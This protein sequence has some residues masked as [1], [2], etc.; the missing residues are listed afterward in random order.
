MPA[1]SRP[2]QR[3]RRLHREGRQGPRE[4]LAPAGPGRRVVPG[5]RTLRLNGGR[6]VRTRSAP[7][8][9]GDDEL[10]RAGPGAFPAALPGGH[11]E[12]GREPGRGQRRPDRLPLPH[13]LPGP[14][15]QPRLERGLAP[16]VPDRPDR[17]ARLRGGLLPGRLP[18][19]NAR[20]AGQPRRHAGLSPAPEELGGGRHRR[21]TIPLVPGPGDRTVAL[22]QGPD[23]LRVGRFPLQ[24]VR[25]GHDERLPRLLR[26]ARR[27]RHE[28]E[29]KRPL[30][31]AYPGRRRNDRPAGQRDQALQASRRVQL[32]QDLQADRRRGPGWLRGAGAAPADERPREPDAVRRRRRVP[33]PQHPGARRPGTG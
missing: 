12:E 16:A 5:N 23:P 14:A 31:G 26:P 20:G 10:I 2:G 6:G 33:A 25:R 8:T 28:E 27:G 7:G 4:K 18:V 32:H 11:R 24:P 3:I 30:R 17:P 9:G 15:G 22:T 1:Q 21:R 29:R 13:L 19:R